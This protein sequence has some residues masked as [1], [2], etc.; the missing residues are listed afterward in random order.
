MS[1]QTRLKNWLRRFLEIE[2]GCATAPVRPRNEHAFAQGLVHPESANPAAPCYEVWRRFRECATLS[3]GCML[4]PMAWCVGSPDR[5]YLGMRAI[6]RG[7]LLCDHKDA[8]IEIGEW[9]YLG[10]D[11]IVSAMKRVK[12]GA[13]T[14]IAH[15]VQIFDNNSHPLDARERHEDY[16]A[17]LAGQPRPYPIP[18]SPVEIGEDCWIGMNSLIM[19]GVRIGNRSVVAAGS[20]VTSDVP[21]DSLMAG[22][23]AR[24]VRS[25]KSS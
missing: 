23:P 25:L 11:V 22:N 24:I 17:I 1:L 7:L 14:L 3:E 6:C 15:G 13:R 4:G 19:K 9:V 8:T 12:I 2:P 10:D 20:V 16:H 18:A 5:V 21:E